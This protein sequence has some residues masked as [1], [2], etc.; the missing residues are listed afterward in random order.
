M[1]CIGVCVF[2]LYASI[3]DMCFS[4]SAYKPVPRTTLPHIML[5]HI[6]PPLVSNH[7]GMVTVVPAH[8]LHTPLPLHPVFT[9]VPSTMHA[10]HDSHSPVHDVH[11][12]P[13][14]AHDVP[15]SPA[16]AL[17]ATCLDV[18]HTTALRMLQHGHGAMLHMYAANLLL[19]GLQRQKE[20]LEGYIQGQHEGGQ[21]GQHEGG[22]HGQHGDGQQQVLDVQRCTLS[23]EY[24][25][26]VLGAIL[27]L[28]EVC[29]E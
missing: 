10:V 25:H 22:E 17:H 23:T 13:S 1:V 26:E 6:G 14:T 12:V 2:G 27:A 19:T 4:Y 15:A 5:P 24:V 18:L 7:T 8:V 3:C 21:H 11:D 29:G 20:A 9:D 16:T 28:W